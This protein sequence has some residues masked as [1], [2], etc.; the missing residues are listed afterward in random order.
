MRAR[1]EGFPVRMLPGVS[2][3]DNLFSDL[4]FDPG[5]SG[6]QTYEAT[7]FLLHK[8]LFEPTAGLVLWQIGVIG[9][10]GWSPRS[11]PREGNLRLLR[12]Y[13]LTRYP[14]GH[15]AI[16]YEAAVLPYGR[17]SI[18]RTTISEILTPKLSTSSTL[19]IPPL[20]E[21]DPDPTMVRMLDEGGIGRDPDR[22]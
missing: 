14:A 3:L 8:P 4:G 21:P 22:V 15:P 11:Q 6:L 16:V 20:P 7:G 9:E 12:D 2:A 5:I 18:Q 17:P 19:F 13:L 1:K 10:R